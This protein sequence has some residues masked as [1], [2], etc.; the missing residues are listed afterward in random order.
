MTVT[1]KQQDGL[2][3]T[4]E[5][6][7][8]P[9]PPSPHR[10]DKIVAVI[11]LAILLGVASAFALIVVFPFFTGT[12]SQQLPSSNWSGYCIASD[13]IAPQPQVTSVSASWTVPTVTVSV[14]NSY[15][16]AWIG[17]GG[18]YDGTLIQVGT[19]QDSINGRAAYSV[20]YE[21][22]PRYT[23]TIY[24]LGIS[25]GDNITAS[26]SLSDRTTNTWSIKI[27]D[28]TDGQSFNRSVTYASSM[29]S[30]EWIVE[31][32]TVTNHIARLANFGHITFTNCTA[33]IGDETGVI[34][35]FPSSQ[36]TLNSR[37]NIAVTVSALASEGSSFTVDY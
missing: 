6:P 19:E 37:Q 33:T 22:L 28:V 11:L 26:I 35:S 10:T 1:V 23:V 27:N 16:A 7:N 29:L 13:L 15:S 24:S 31:L 21:L 12:P 2:F 4:S 9:P 8:P 36:I 30:A 32:P 17:V 18:E 25:P 5:Y 20:W 14:D 3:L 34:S